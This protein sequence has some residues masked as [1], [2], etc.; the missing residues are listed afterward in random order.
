M[1]PTVGQALRSWKHAKAVALLSIAAL[2]IGIGSTTAIYTVISGVLL[3]P[4]PYEHGDRFV[5]IFGG[6]VK[7]PTGISG[8]IYPDLQ[9]YRDRS[10]SFDGFGWF[11]PDS[12]N[13]TAPGQPQHLVGAA[14]TPD[15]ARLLGVTPLAGEWF[16]QEGQAVISAALWQRLGG[17]RSILGTGL[18]L[19]GRSYTVTGVMPAWFRL[20]ITG[21][22]S[23]ELHNDVW[24]YLD[25]GG[26][27]QNP[28]EGMFFCYAR[29]K[30]GVS[31]EAATADAERVAV[32]IARES[33]GDHPG[34]TARVRD[35]RET[36][37]GLIRPTLLLLLAASAFLLLITCAN[38]AG[39]LLS[40]SVARAR[41]TAIR[42]AL[43]AAPRQLA[44]QYLVEGLLVSLAGGAL[45]VL[46]SQ[47]MVRVILAFGGDRIPRADQIRVDWK[48]LLFVLAVAALTALLSSLAPLWQASRISPREVLSEEVRSSA[49]KRSRSLSQWLVVAEIAL[50]FALLTVGAL[51]IMHLRNLSNTNAGFSPD[52]LLSFRLTLSTEMMEKGR[53]AYEHRM[54]D[55][56]QHVPGVTAVAYSNQVPLA[57]CCMSSAIYP[58]DRPAN[59]N[60]GQRIS[61]MIVTPDYL[62]VLRIP[63]R[64]GR[65]LNDHD[66]SEELLN[67]VINQAAANSYWPGRNALGALGRFAGPAGS[68]FQVVGIIGDVRNDGL[69]KP[70]VPEI[71]MSGDIVPTTPISFIVRSGLPAASLYNQLRQAVQRVDPSQPIHD[72]VTLPEVKRQSLT[73]QRAA[74]AMTGFFAGAALLL[75][76]LGV[77][78][79][80]AYSVRQRRVEI[81]TRIALGAARRQVLFMIVGGGLRMAGLGI[82]LGGLAVAGASWFLI[83]TFGIKDAGMLPF[84]L[85]TLVVASVVALS[86]FFPALRATL[87]SPMVAIRNEQPSMWQSARQQF[88][89][90]VERMSADAEAAP[91]AVAALLTEVGESV[92][93]AENYSQ[94]REQA[95]MRVCG[96]VGAEWALLLEKLTP[97]EF[98][99]TAGTAGA[100]QQM[101][102]PAAGFLANRLGY[103]SGALPI[104]AGDFTTWLRWAGEQRPHHVDELKRLQQSGAALVVALHSTSG[105]LGLLLLGP[106]KQG[107]AYSADQRQVLRHS[108]QVIALLV[109]NARLTERMVDQEKVR[110]DL[111]LAAEVQRRLLPDKPPADGVVSLA[112]MSLPARTVGGDYYDFFDLG[113]G[114]IGIALAD[115]AGKGIAAALLMSVVQASLRMIL[116]DGGIT[117]PQLAAKMNRF[118]H[119][120]TGPQSYATFFYCELDPV[121]SRLRYVNAGHNPPYLLR[122]NG[123]IEEL[124]AGGTVIGLLAQARYEEGS[125]DLHRGDILIAFTD[126]VPEALNP[127]EEEFGEDRIKELLRLWSGGSAAAASENLATTMR[128]WIQDAAQYDD[129]TFIILKVNS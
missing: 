71:Y 111:A 107:D 40:R 62:K 26:R 66:N 129:L 18:T 7:N 52:Q 115:I 68:R 39:L 98:K 104:T 95:L 16:R 88:Q 56:L 117:L 75:A 127:Q 121:S 81:G 90:A 36:A 77:Y 49:G 45:G 125:V 5:A 47:A 76:A 15:L 128:D 70:T 105:I 91:L 58:E 103:Y 24:V 61:L 94:A 97:A 51:L 23:E 28:S 44:S 2:A 67:V 73:L 55:E 63:L 79:L 6:D 80:V 48:V 84:I 53:V 27:G 85:S 89:R 64:A 54:L 22:E 50:A 33:P 120:S 17:N 100:P 20:P 102:L 11:R 43:G 59:L 114:R 42:V 25:P 119:R 126:G 37:I 92:R 112:A 35:L 116:A 99:R 3:S 8:N 31:L 34:Y 109:E 82:V 38:T 69:D 74:S 83:R 9:K 108:A 57:G 60:A 87:L 21:V 14:A 113:D 30:P 13:L 46:V 32:Q 106:P 96:S 110:R 29:R 12:Y 19:N 118:L 101:E 4:L 1:L 124:S 65:F 78:G 93:G 41:E 72:L 123:E 86:S 122:A 10:Q